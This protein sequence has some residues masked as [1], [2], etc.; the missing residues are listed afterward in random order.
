MEPPIYCSDVEQMDPVYLKI[1]PISIRL[2]EEIKCYK[3]NSMP[4]P[5]RGLTM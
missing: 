3:H 4:I 2:K 5:L 1:L